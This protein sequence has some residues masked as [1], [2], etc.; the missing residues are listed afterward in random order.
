MK[1]LSHRERRDLAIFS[2]GVANGIPEGKDVWHALAVRAVGQKGAK[3]LAAQL[4]KTRERLV[5]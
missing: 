1:P 2:L 3:H 4:A 5:G